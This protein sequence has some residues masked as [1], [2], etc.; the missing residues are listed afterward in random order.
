LATADL[1]FDPICPW[2]WQVSRWLTEAE[3]VRDIHWRPHVMSLSVLNEDRPD[4]TGDDHAALRDAWL[5]VRVIAATGLS[6][7]NE[8][9]RDLYTALGPLIHAKR[10][11]IG[12][13]MFALAFGRAGL[14]HSLANAARDPF[15]DSTVRASHHAG[16][17]PL[18]DVA[19]CPVLH[20]AGPDGESIAFMGPLVTPYP[21]GEA[22]GRL[23]DAVTLAAATD[24]FFG[25]RRLL[26]RSPAVD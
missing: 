14:P 17:D 24:G 1:W 8:A 2:A 22:A 26:T 15:Y 12:R 16:V 6:L 23:W 20:V 7:G 13:D 21:R 25:L 3:Q 10:M 4:L 19:A 9:V 18:G 11:A 5:P